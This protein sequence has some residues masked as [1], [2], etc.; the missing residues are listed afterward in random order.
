[1]VLPK[2]IVAWNKMKKVIENE[3][4]FIWYVNVET[5]VH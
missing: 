2:N 3:S 5:Y 4:Y 1:M